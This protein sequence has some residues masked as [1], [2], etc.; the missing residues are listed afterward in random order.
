M[1]ADIIDLVG[2]WEQARKAWLQWVR[3][4]K[5]I[6]EAWKAR[7]NT[8]KAYSSG[9]RLF[10][11]GHP[12]LLRVGFR[13]PRPWAATSAD[14]RAF[15]D[16]LTLSGR[17]PATINQRLA[18]CKSM[19]GYIR[20]KYRIPRLPA[21][22]ALVAAGLLYPDTEDQENRLALLNPNHNNPFNSSKI[23]RIPV[24]PFENATYP[25][26]SEMDA[27]LDQI[28]LSSLNGLRD[29]ALFYLMLTSTR[30]I[31]EA[32]LIK[33]GDIYTQEDGQIV[34]NYIGKGRKKGREV[35]GPKAWLA[36]KRYLQAA[37]RLNAMQPDHYLFLPHEGGANGR[38]TTNPRRPITYTTVRAALKKY[39]LL[40][41]ID[42]EKVH[43]HA[44]R[45]RGAHNRRED[46]ERNGGQADLLA[47]KEKLG[48]ESL[49]TTEGYIR[50]TNQHVEDRYLAM[51]E[52]AHARQLP[53][54]PEKEVA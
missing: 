30:R 12:D 27:I 28:D 44:L 11:Y 35:I 41:G 13:P 1:N 23:E 8:K 47:L 5:G 52:A 2:M 37:G 22:E 42:T 15:K 19:F 53:E 36:I 16:A 14:A 45:H 48:H 26:R 51:A 34:Y 7:D 25:A 17:A 3:T 32:R 49:G 21:L 50:S 54:L 33:W 38:Y 29:Y 46:M 18:G 20:D 24:K 9:S 39:G 40:A 10:L 43:L 6:D 31:S 4:H